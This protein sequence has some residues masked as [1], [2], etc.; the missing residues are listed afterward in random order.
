MPNRF[1]GYDVL[2]KR[3]TPSWDAATRRVIDRRLATRRDPGFFTEQEWQT[4]TALAGR[5]V[6]QPKSH[7]PVPIAA[8]V[9]QKMAL[10]RTDGYRDARLPKM[11]EAW[12]RGLRAVDA[13]AAGR[14]GKRFHLLTPPQQDA[15]LTAMQQ[16]ALSD[17]AWDGMP[18]KLWFSQ[19]LVHDIVAAYYAHPTAWNEIGFGGPASPRGY[20]RM[21][22]NRRDPWEAAEVPHAD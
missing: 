22:F 5:I 7:P 9:D 20:V 21:G 14:H 13:E 10:D 18:G 8:M 11:Q 2:A 6:P 16:G 4:L 19:R 15:L 1:P 12:R 3:H 17:P